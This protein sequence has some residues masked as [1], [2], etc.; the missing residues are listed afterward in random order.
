MPRILF[1]L[2]GRAKVLFEDNATGRQDIL[3]DCLRK[4]M[5]LVD[6]HVE[7]SSLWHLQYDAPKRTC[8]DDRNLLTVTLGC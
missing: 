8:L 7:I 6:K 3:C 4:P 5:G 1:Q 2:V